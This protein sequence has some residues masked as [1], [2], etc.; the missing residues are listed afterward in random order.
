MCLWKWLRRILD[1]FILVHD[2]SSIILATRK[3]KKKNI[4]KKKK[5]I[6]FLKIKNQKGKN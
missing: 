5:K 2:G 3:K 4:K 1:A 6:L